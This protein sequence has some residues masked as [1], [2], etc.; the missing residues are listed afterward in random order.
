MV[1]KSAKAVEKK[2]GSK[3]K[4]KSKSKSKPTLK[5]SKKTTAKKTTVDTKKKT[6]EKVS[7]PKKENVKIEPEVLPTVSINSAIKHSIIRPDIVKKGNS[8]KRNLCLNLGKNKETVKEEFKEPVNGVANEKKEVPLQD[9]PLLVVTP[10]VSS[11]STKK[12]SSINQN[13]TFFY[14]PSVF[15]KFDITV[16]DSENETDDIYTSTIEEVDNIKTDETYDIESEIAS[17]I[18][19]V[20]TE[21]E[22]NSSDLIEDICSFDDITNDQAEISDNSII[23]ETNSDDVT[24][25]IDTEISDIFNITGEIVEENENSINDGNINSDK[26]IDISKVKTSIGN[27]YSPL[28]GDIDNGLDIV[29]SEAD[30]DTELEIEKEYDSLIETN[31]E[32]EIIDEEVDNL[33]S[34]DCAEI[35]NKIDDYSINSEDE[36]INDVND[37]IQNISEINEVSNNIQDE[38]NYESN[39]ISDNTQEDSK[40]NYEV[41][42]TLGDIQNDSETSY[43]ANEIL[44]DTQEEVIDNIDEVTETSDKVEVQDKDIDLNIY[45]NNYD[46]L[47]SE[48]FYEKEN[49]S[50]EN[51]DYTNG[52]VLDEAADNIIPFN[53]ID[54]TSTNLTNKLSFEVA[55][56]INTDVIGFSK[57]ESSKSSTPAFS[58]IFKKFSF[59]ETNFINSNLNT[60][61]GNSFLQTDVNSLKNDIHNVLNNFEPTA[62]PLEAIQEV[63]AANTV[64]VPEVQ[65][66]P[67]PISDDLSLN[68]EATYYNNIVVPTKIDNINDDISSLDNE[69]EDVNYIKDIETIAESDI[70]NDEASSIESIFEEKLSSSE[71]DIDEKMKEELLTEVLSFESSNTLNVSFDL[72]NTSEKIELESDVENEILTVG[73]PV[74]KNINEENGKIQNNSSE[75]LYNAN[76]EITYCSENLNKEDFGISEEFNGENIDIEIDKETNVQHT[77]VSEFFNEGNN[78]DNIDTLN[79]ID[80]QNDISSEIDIDNDPASDLFK[81]MDSLSDIIS[82]LENEE[83]ALVSSI[84]D[85]NTLLISEETQKVY[86]PYTS[87]EVSEKLNNSKEYKTINDVIESEYTVPL[88]VYKNPISA[89]FKEAYTLMRVKE[90]S[91]VRAAIDLGLDLMFTSNLNPAIITACKNI[92]ELNSYLD[93]LYN[94]ET[95]KFEYFNIIYKISDGN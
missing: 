85:C 63:A 75:D 48:N 29:V 24:N 74:E 26:I 2:A 11:A 56:S 41:D 34:S 8:R 12:D 9:V 15:K 40:T 69:A 88:S 90:K 62:K 36:V 27:D 76:E 13:A 67:S 64:A 6:T 45:F 55:G 59:D 7:K 28:L 72:D 23:N 1:T 84:Y 58:N 80:I 57:P 51:D 39:E 87:E 60:P 35:T 19:N 47:P 93:C 46:V 95:D 86:L 91:S 25:I 70:V 14:E 78:F 54:E 92:V 89:R 43:E 71:C 61:F 52:V 10:V 82:K 79:K 44:S 18:N 33:N 66:A 17:A 32:V 5:I 77:D 53:N 20:I 81:M 31:S 50:I 16:T 4:A 42:K 83:E 94:N 65:V 22:D 37:Y 49:S 38:T 21:I 68:D 3:S 30:V 73:A